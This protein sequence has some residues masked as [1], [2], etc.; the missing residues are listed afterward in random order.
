MK[1]AHDV[2]YIRYALDD[3]V[4]SVYATGSSS[5]EE[6]K[7]AG[8]FDNATMV[9]SFKKGTVVTLTMS[10]SA[11]YGYDQ[12]CEIFGTEGLASVA[13]EFTD[14][15]VHSNVNGVQQTRLK[16]SFPQRFNAA[17][18]AELEVFADCILDGSPWPIYKDDCIAT[19]KIADCAK[20]SAEL[21]EVVYLDR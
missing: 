17:F 20:L 14:S 2:D 15:S 5:A 16:H 13:N 10:R 6:L 7:E 4:E 21:K 8:V 19:Q 3:E 9:L 1:Q 11:C 18:D 12:R